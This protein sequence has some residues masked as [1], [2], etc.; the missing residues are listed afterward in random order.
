MTERAPDLNGALPGSLLSCSYLLSK[1]AE[2]A[3]DPRGYGVVIDPLRTGQFLIGGT[4]E[5]SGDTANDL[6]A[7]RTM[8]ASAARLL[9]G[10][11]RLRALRAFA[12]VRSATSDG[13]P[14]VG[15]VPGYENVVVATGFE[16]DGICLGP[17]M[18]RTVS[19]LI[20]GEAC[21]LDLAP[22]A[23]GRFERRSLVA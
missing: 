10:I 21:E 11:A 18:G 23:P 13:L 14:L 9:P 5:E 19:R 12:G 22:F 4:R 15:R 6:A 16:G 3:G 2:H 17:L 7:I 20:A 1:K 8:L